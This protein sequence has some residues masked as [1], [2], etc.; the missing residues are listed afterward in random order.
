ML[1][2]KKTQLEKP[3]LKIKKT[4]TMKTISPEDIQ[5][6][7]TSLNV[8]C[9]IKV[10]SYVLENYE[11]AERQY[12]QD[13]WSE[14]VETLIYEVQPPQ[15]TKTPILKPSSYFLFGS[16]ICNKY[17]I[18]LPFLIENLNA[19]VLDGTIF[20]WKGESVSDLL[21]AATGWNDYQEI[22][23]TEF[24]ILSFLKVDHPDRVKTYLQEIDKIWLSNG[25]I[26]L[27]Y[28]EYSGCDEIA[29]I[30]DILKIQSDVFESFESLTEI[31][32]HVLEL[33]PTIE[34]AL[35]GCL[36]SLLHLHKNHTT[37]PKFY[38]IDGYWKDSKETFTERIVTNLDNVN[39]VAEKM[40]DEEI[41]LNH[42]KG[43]LLYF[44]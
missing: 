23:E 40:P 30:N 12:T 28:P 17:R 7:C 38:L 31:E 34:D 29:L 22:S 4:Y 42:A 10:I 37:E 8:E 14:I 44:P 33:Y 18:G 32:K 20:E 13:N 3:L 2:R 1:T 6:V 39:V 26:E 21:N 9:T 11:A 27:W 43:N 15:A 41:F 36:D 25:G 16:W 19:D 5:T 35:K 24:K